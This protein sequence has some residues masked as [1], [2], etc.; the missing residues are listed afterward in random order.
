MS[1]Q[2][3]VYAASK[4]CLS[5]RFRLNRESA[6]K[7]VN[8]H[9]PARGEAVKPLR[10][11]PGLY[12]GI[13]LRQAGRAFIETTLS[14]ERLPPPVYFPPVLLTNAGLC[15]IANS[16]I[17]IF[18]PARTPSGMNAAPGAATPACFVMISAAFVTLLNL[19][20]TKNR[21]IPV[22]TAKTAGAIICAR[23]FIAANRAALQV[24]F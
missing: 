23:L 8:A 4:R 24:T 20:A 16:A 12:V 14:L 22:V 3:V 17:R 1:R 18:A 5:Q 10:L 6:F 21:S 13:N 15:L 11:F 7:T 19:T 2:A 9:R